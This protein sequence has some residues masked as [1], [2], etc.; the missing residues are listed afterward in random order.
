MGAEK[1]LLPPH[2]NPL[3]HWG[4]GDKE[5]TPFLDQEAISKPIFC[6]PERS[7]GSQAF[8]K[9]RFFAALRMTSL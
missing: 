8:K 9:T 4:R 7:E 6:H 3:P 1:L 5:V 2:P